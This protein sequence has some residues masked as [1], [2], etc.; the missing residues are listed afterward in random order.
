M[1][2]MWHYYIEFFY[3]FRFHTAITFKLKGIP[4]RFGEIS[5]K[6]IHKHI[7]KVILRNNPSYFYSPHF[8][9]YKSLLNIFL[10]G[11]QLKNLMSLINAE[12]EMRIRFALKRFSKIQNIF[13]LPNNF[14]LENT[15]YILF[16]LFISNKQIKFSLKYSPLNIQYSE[17]LIY[18]LFPLNILQR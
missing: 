4:L 1:G 11:V 17:L 6:K 8:P 2:L 16:M 12:A 7:W 15:F 13:F 9:K 3:S 14:I 10:S 18:I 5:T